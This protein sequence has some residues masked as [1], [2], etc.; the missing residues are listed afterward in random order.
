MLPSEKIELIIRL[1][2]FITKMIVINNNHIE[3]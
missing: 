2:K 1:S 3:N